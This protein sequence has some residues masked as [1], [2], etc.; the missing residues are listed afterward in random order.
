MNAPSVR[1]QNAFAN[2]TSQWVVRSTTISAL[3]FAFMMY[4]HELPR[5]DAASRTKPR[6]GPCFLKLSPYEAIAMETEWSSGLIEEQYYKKIQKVKTP[7]M[8]ALYLYIWIRCR[9]QMQL[10]H[11]YFR[12]WSKATDTI[13][14]IPID[15]LYIAVSATKLFI[16][17]WVQHTPTHLLLSIKQKLW[18]RFL[19]YSSLQTLDT[20]H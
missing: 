5:D 6:S 16:S 9:I 10:L 18:Q 7:K 17:N 2:R 3:C 4:F 12:A 13:Q 1:D 8:T 20:R 14:H 19:R 11:R 15:C